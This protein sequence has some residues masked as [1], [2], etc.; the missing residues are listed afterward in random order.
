MR[1]CLGLLFGLALVA[2]VAPGCGPALNEEELGT[3]IYDPQEIPRADVRFDLPDFGPS[4]PVE[5][6]PGPPY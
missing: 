2:L 1:T 3:I 6:G 4:S 5:S